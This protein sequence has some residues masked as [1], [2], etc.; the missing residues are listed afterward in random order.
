MRGHFSDLV[1]EAGQVFDMLGVGEAAGAGKRT[2]L[3]AWEGADHG[4]VPYFIYCNSIQYFINK[5]NI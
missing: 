4:G 5:V 2:G 3:L 1:T